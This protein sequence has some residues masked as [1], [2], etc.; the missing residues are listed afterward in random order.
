MVECLEVEPEAKFGGIFN[1]KGKVKLWFSRDD[2]RLCAKMT[3]KVPLAKVKAVLIEV[4]GPG[5]DNWVNPQADQDTEDD[6]YED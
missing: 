1:R 6:R 5:D 3:G 4:V 2:R